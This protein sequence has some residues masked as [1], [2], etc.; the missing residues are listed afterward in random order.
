M[1]KFIC[2]FMLILTVFFAFTACG[3]EEF[4]CDSCGENVVSKKHEVEFL[5]VK[6]EICDDCND[7]Y[8]EEMDALEDELGDLL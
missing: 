3:K 7:E 4:K 5:G 6:M 2:C 8:E 1:K